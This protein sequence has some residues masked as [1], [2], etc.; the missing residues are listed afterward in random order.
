MR[1]FI[2][3][4]AIGGLVAVIGLAQPAAAAIQP[5]AGLEPGVHL[6]LGLSGAAADLAVGPVAVGV[7]A[8]P[9][10]SGAAAC[11]AA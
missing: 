4:G 9:R 5:R 3:L 11:S 7:A 6:G 2:C 1:N 10:R 8:G